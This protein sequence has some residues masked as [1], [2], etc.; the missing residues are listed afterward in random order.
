M[1]TRQG[2]ASESSRARPVA[3]TAA[4]CTKSITMT[5]DPHGLLPGLGDALAEALEAAHTAAQAPPS[6]VR[7]LRAAGA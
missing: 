4:H 2:Y 6:N 5:L 7:A 1:P 3:Q